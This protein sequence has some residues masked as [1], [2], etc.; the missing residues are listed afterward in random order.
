MLLWSSRQE[1][2]IH[3]LCARVCQIVRNSIRIIH[4][5]RIFCQT[6]SPFVNVSLCIFTGSLII[7]VSS[8]TVS[9]FHVFSIIIFKTESLSTH[10]SIR[11]DTWISD[12]RS[13]SF[14]PFFGRYQ[15][16]TI[17]T[18][19]TI[20]SCT[21]CIF[22]KW[23]RFNIVTVNRRNTCFW[24]VNNYQRRKVTTIKCTNTTYTNICTITTGFTRTLIYRYTGYQ[25]GKWTW[26]ICS[27]TTFQFTG[28]NCSN[29]TG[30]IHL[31][32]YT[33]TYY[34]NLI[35]CFWIFC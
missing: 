20:N 19:R 16:Y 1:Q 34:Y 33:V 13:L 23:N 24:T 8:P 29:R 18:S 22:Q 14:F 17:S 30:Q 7:T 6:F 2:F 11:Y 12:F 32:L 4:A 21:S 27:R 28:R 25:T 35:Q 26:Q 31:F 5:V 9:H 10:L 3:P 15:D